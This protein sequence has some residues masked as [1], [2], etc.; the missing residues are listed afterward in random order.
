MSAAPRLSFALLVALALPLTLSACADDGANAPDD[1]AAIDPLDALEADATDQLFSLGGPAEAKGVSAARVIKRHFDLASMGHIKFQQL[2]RGVPVF[3]GEAIA[4]FDEAGRLRGFTD[5][6]IGGVDVDVRPAYGADEALDIAASVALPWHAQSH[7]PTAALWV[8]RHKDQ[9]HLVWRVQQQRTE[10]DGVPTM[11]VLF[12]DAHTGEVVWSYE[13]LQTAT[14]TGATNFY[15]TVSFECYTDGTSFFT[16]NQADAVGTFSFGNTTSTVYYVSSASTTFGTDQLTK[17]AVEA[18]F[19]AQETIDYYF[20][21]FGRDGI[22]GAGGPADVTAHGVGYLTSY[23]SYSRNYVNAFWDGASMTYGDGDGLNSGSLTVLDVGGHEFTHGVT[24]Y[25]ANLTYSGEPGHLNESYS[26][27]FGAMVERYARGE[28]LRTWLVGEDTWTP[29]TSGDALRYMNDPADDGVSRDFWTTSI[30]SVDVH[31]GSGV[32]NLAFYLLSEGGTHPRGKSTVNVTAI[33][34]DDAAAIWYLALTSYMTSSTNF[35]GARTAQINAATALFGATS[36]Q[37]QSVTNSWA[38][39]GVGSAWGAPAPTCTTRTYSG[40]ITRA[41][42][43]VYAPSSTGVTAGTYPMS[44]ALT[45]PSSANFN[46]ALEKKSGSRW[47]AVATSAGSTSTEA[48]SSYTGT[49]GTYRAT[50]TS[51]TGTGSFSLTWCY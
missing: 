2:H 41:G 16:E 31:Y 27:V 22:D 42:R 3:G 17:N 46:L 24:Q 48:I 34:A 28:D 19:V 20:T 32:P 15:G 33:G 37:V 36:Q 47:S 1:S 14:C 26:D 29:G 23:T 49:S 12:I 7:A 40:S 6:L 18:N 4:H 11:P 35:A 8:L 39:V 10:G 38:A 30:G 25:E 44:L 45:G 50:V 5:D 9:D 21:T 43:S 51:V 13:N